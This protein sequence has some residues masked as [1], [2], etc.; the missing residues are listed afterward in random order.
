LPLALGAFGLVLAIFVAMLHAMLPLI[1]I[2][3]VV[4]LVVRHRR[5]TATSL[6]H[7]S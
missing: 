1:V 4:W 2:G 5:P 3:V 6:P 7:A